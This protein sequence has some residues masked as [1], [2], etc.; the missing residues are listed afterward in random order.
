MYYILDTKLKSQ[1]TNM[2]VHKGKKILKIQQEMAF[3]FIILGQTVPDPLLCSQSQKSP[4]MTSLVAMLEILKDRL[5]TYFKVLVLTSKADKQKR[6]YQIHTIGPH[7]KF[8]IH[9]SIM[10]GHIKAIF[11]AK[12]KIDVFRIIFS[13]LAQNTILSQVYP[14]NLHDLNINSA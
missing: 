1:T 14:Y 8:N 2:S 3:P 12:Q 5:L 7:K 6:Q 13:L 4:V 10:F 9:K 11:S